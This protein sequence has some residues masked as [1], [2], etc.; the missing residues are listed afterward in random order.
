[1]YRIIILLLLCAYTWPALAQEKKDFAWYNNETFRLYQNSNWR[2]LVKVGE[3]ALKENYDFFYMRVRLGA[4]Y[5][6]LQQYRMAIRQFKKALEFNADDPL[7]IE[8]L[9]YSY[10]FSGRYLDANLVWEKH[11]AILKN[12]NIKSPNNFITGM[13]TEGG[14]KISS[15]NEEGVGNITN[16]HIGVAQQL[17]ARL[18]LYQGYTRVAQS[19]TEYQ[20]YTSGGLFGPP[21]TYV[22]E[23][24][25]KYPQH[26]Y[27]IKADVPIVKGLL[28]NGSFHSQT[29]NDSTGARVNNRGYMIGLKQNNTISEIYLAYAA[30]DINRLSQVQYMG[31]ITIYPLASSK[32]YLQT[33]YTYHK[34]D[35]IVNNVYYL[36]LGGSL[37]NKFWLDAYGSLGGMKNFQELEG[38][39]MYNIPNK[40]NYRWGTTGSLYLG[41]AGKLMVGYMLENK[42]D[43]SDPNITFNHHYIF[44]GLHLIFNKR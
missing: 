25:Y 21:R 31:G 3:E 38:Y 36:K 5:Y 11:K 41:S 10:V 39:Q 30:S 8:Y 35:G 32:L 22:Q 42:Q 37:T 13:Y 15:Q 27:F 12:R 23:I 16:F 20:Y 28:V 26:E 34:E 1:M 44:V 6:G 29:F 18:H 43:S 40:I 24:K 33:L 17:G 4:A 2:S 14:I 7:S 9:Y 19:F